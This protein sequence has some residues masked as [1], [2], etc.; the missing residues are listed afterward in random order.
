MGFNLI[1]LQSLLTTIKFL[2][3]IKYLIKADI[4]SLSMLKI[5]TTTLRR[6]TFFSL[7]K[8]NI[9]KN[10][11]K[12]FIFTQTVAWKSDLEKP[13][14]L[15]E[16]KDT[17]DLE[18]KQEVPT[19]ILN[20]ITNEDLKVVILSGLPHPWNEKD[21]S[22]YFD[23]AGRDIL[24]VNVVRNR[25]GT[26]TGKALVTFRNSSIAE[27]FI[28]D[29]NFN[30]IETEEYTQQI[31][32][33]VFTL[34]KRKDVSKTN[35]GLKQVYI[36]NLNFDCM[37]EDLYNFAADFGA[38]KNVELPT[39]QTGK[40]KGFGYVTFETAADAEKFIKF[41]DEMDFMGRKIR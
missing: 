27:K 2:H 12:N 8:A 15:T 4:F 3:L 25:L 13:N 21:I 31:G 7:K 22:K 1:Y 30:L 23:K 14:S 34:K 35:Y 39:K 38:V 28:A 26:N 41:A 33:E 24:K 29:W 19:S 18:E 10:Y 16:K 5:F 36:Y 40:N 37:N 20:S 6:G 11:L 17:T 32:A 9:P